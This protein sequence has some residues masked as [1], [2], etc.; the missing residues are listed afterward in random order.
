MENKR[1]QIF[2]SSTY[3]DLIEIRQKATE[4]ILKTGN[5]PIGMEMFSADDEE[6]WKQIKKGIESSDYY[7]VI[8]GHRYG[9]T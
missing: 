7:V 2:I 8:V 9:S 1:Y 6:Q 5:I 4:I 3:T